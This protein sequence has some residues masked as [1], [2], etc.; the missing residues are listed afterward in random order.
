MCIRDRVYLVLSAVAVVDFDYRLAAHPLAFQ[1]DA[2]SHAMFRIL[3]ESHYPYY[4]KE[5]LGRYVVYHRTV[6]Y[7]PDFH[8]FILRHDMSLFFNAQQITD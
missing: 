8:Y 2:E 7:R 6:L 4:G 1:I 5:R 3:V